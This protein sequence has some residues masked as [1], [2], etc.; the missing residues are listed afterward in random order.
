LFQFFGWALTL[1]LLLLHFFLKIINADNQGKI[2]NSTIFLLRFTQCVGVMELIF[3]YLR[4]SSS[5]VFTTFLQLMSRLLVCIVFLSK[6]DSAATVSFF[7]IPW[8]IADSTRL[9][10]YVYKE[11]IL[12]GKLRYNLFLIL[13]PVGCVG[14]IRLME[15]RINELNEGDNLYYLIR[16]VQVVFFF[17]LIV[18]YCH[19]L[20]QRKKFY[21][22]NNEK[23]KV[24][25]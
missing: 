13:Y 5:S 17:G 16:F 22:N 14:E 25:V 24:K 23:V 18:L 10:Y 4:I 20:K 3:S 6:N 15:Q 2:F 11:S 9:L 7:L 21:K 8:S 19:L 12:L 1:N